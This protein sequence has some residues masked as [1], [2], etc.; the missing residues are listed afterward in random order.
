MIR[1]LHFTPHTKINLK[2]I[3]DINV[4]AETIKLVEEN[5]EANLC[6]FGLSN[7]FLDITPKA[8]AKKKKLVGGH[9]NQKNFVFQITPSRK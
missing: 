1:G 3:R 2:W 7:S 8:Q 5:M 6:D 9:K 4:R